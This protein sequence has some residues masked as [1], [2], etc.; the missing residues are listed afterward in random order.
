MSPDRIR[1]KVVTERSDWVREMLDRIRALPLDS[2]DDFTADP[3]NVDAAESCLRR[4]LEAMLDLGR[5]MLAKGF[6][7]APAE[8]RQVAVQLGARDVLTAEEAALFAKMAGY[9]NRMV[10]FYDR[11]SE[12]E[13][14]EL[15]TDDLGDLEAV[16]GGVHRWLQDH[17]DQVDPSV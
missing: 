1:R 14:Y 4:A 7:D 17:P 9:R 3:R 13:L 8:Y 5:H 6:G 10:H 11:V 15:C 16:L 2:L 12:A